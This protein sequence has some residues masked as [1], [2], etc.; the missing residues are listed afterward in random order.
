M[1]GHNV[2]ISIKF[3]VYSNKTLKAIPPLWRLNTDVKKTNY[4]AIF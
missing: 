1:D 4:K 3:F 2:H